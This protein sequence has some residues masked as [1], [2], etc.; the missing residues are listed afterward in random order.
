MYWLKVT[1][2]VVK[3][4][5]GWRYQCFDCNSFNNEQC[6][7][8][9]GEAKIALIQLAEFVIFS[10]EKSFTVLYSMTRFNVHKECRELLGLKG[11]E[12]QPVPST[13]VGA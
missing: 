2:G 5:Q 13:W 8:E 1:N 12:D 11:Q 3:S 4:K 6:Q 10:Y 7:W 9:R